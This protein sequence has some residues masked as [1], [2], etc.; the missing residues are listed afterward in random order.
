MKTC[1]DLRREWK[2][3]LSGDSR[4][5]AREGWKE[6]LA[7]CADCR[8][9]ADDIQKILDGAEA[10]QADVRRAMESV[11]WDQFSER[12][13]DAALAKRPRASAAPARPGRFWAA[14]WTPRWRPVFAG[15]L[16]GVLL[17]AAG[18]Y[19]ALKP[20]A[21]GRSPA[22][23]LR[24]SGEFIDKVEYSMAKRETIDYLAK[25]QALLLDFV[26]ATPAAAAR[27]L[28]SG[29]SIRRTQDLLAKKRYINREL[30]SVPMA[31]AREICNQIELLFEE[32]A[33]LGGELTAEE[34]A[35]IQRFVED[36]DLLLR[37]QLVRRELEESEV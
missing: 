7:M 16:A 28:R 13:A 31:K 37:I 1:A 6:H 8:R 24:P 10:L 26:Q 29:P 33:Q 27:S 5:E 4:P 17:G 34:A 2:K 35:K 9:E 25:S 12:I 30:D 32:L 18:M 36:R 3:A 21:L 14:L 23:G 22:M 19:L 20:G 11:D 15:A